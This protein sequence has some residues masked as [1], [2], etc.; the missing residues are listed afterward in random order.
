MAVL[1]ITSHDRS[2]HALRQ[3]CVELVTQY[4]LDRSQLELKIIKVIDD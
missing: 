4:V 1:Y 3:A 2:G